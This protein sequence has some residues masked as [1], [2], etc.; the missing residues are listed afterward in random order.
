MN[1]HR[2]DAEIDLYQAKEEF[3]TEIEKTGW[4]IWKIVSRKMKKL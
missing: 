2:Q 3:K 1:L 4:P